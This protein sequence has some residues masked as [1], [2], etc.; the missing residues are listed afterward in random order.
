MF[1]RN[2][3]ERGHV[4][5]HEGAEA[6]PEVAGELAHLMGQLVAQVTDGVQ[7]ILHREGEVHQV[8]EIHRVVLH[9][10]HL[11]L[12]PRLAS[13]MSKPMRETFG[14]K[15]CRSDL[16]LFQGTNRQQTPTG[17]QAEGHLLRHD[18]DDVILGHAF[19]TEG[20]VPQDRNTTA[21]ALHEARVT[22]PFLQVLYE[23]TARRQSL[24]PAEI[25]KD[26]K[27]KKIKFP[28]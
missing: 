7:I 18:L 22:A 12:E 21:G 19:R 20:N 16:W 2:V 24:P 1:F 4:L 6:Q 11:Q 3:G 13:W 25:L 8:V 26:H 28:R 5:V 27:N 10:P 9:L 15:L 17:S 14:N 23:I